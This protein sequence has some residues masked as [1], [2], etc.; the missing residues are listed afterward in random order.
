[1][2]PQGAG[3]GRPKTST[4]WGRRP[5]TP[6][7]TRTPRRAENGREHLE[8]TA[9][10][11]ELPVAMRAPR[12]GGGG[13]RTICVCGQLWAPFPRRPRVTLALLG[14]RPHRQQP[15]GRSSMQGANEEV[16]WVD[17]ACVRSLARRGTGHRHPG[18]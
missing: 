14:S 17:A 2:P 11:P 15:P 5:V 13:W 10:A 12:G 4:G 6:L 9:P 8:T 7:H 3:P 18:G 16:P 1:M